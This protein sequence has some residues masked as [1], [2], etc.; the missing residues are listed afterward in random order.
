MFRKNKRILARER[1]ENAPAARRKP[2][3]DPANAHVTALAFLGDSV[4]ETLMRERL[5]R[6]DLPPD[7]LHRACTAR[8]NA[9]AQASAVRVLTPHLT[10]EELDALH[11]GRNRRTA[12][13]PKQGT[14]AEYR[15]ATGLETLFGH[16]YL[17]GQT[18]RM[19]ELFEIC[20]RAA[21]ETPT[22]KTE[23]EL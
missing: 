4:Y 1:A 19:R 15:A 2:D 20:Y 7:A 17:T 11:K 10:P 16:L 14:G 12:H 23:T 8:V 3:F 18:R 21:P 6:E 5:V 22:K 9:A 13:R